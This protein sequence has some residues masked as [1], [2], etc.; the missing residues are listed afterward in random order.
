MNNGKS[1]QI[2]ER[3][4]EIKKEIEYEYTGTLDRITNPKKRVEWI[5]QNFDPTESPQHNKS[6]D[7]FLFFSYEKQK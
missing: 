2:G 4:S 5:F 3:L 7:Q 6:H 1:R